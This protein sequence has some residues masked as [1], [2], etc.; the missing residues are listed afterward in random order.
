[1]SAPSD[2]ELIAKAIAAAR[3][4]GVSEPDI[5]RALAEEFEPR[6]N[7]SAIVAEMRLHGLAKARVVG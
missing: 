4:A 7:L 6:D 3:A 1:M 5:A 2:D